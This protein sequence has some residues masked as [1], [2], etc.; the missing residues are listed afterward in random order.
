MK[1]V[2]AVARLFGLALSGSFLTMFAQNKG[3]LC[4]RKVVFFCLDTCRLILYAAISFNAENCPSAQ[5]L[6]QIHAAKILCRSHCVCFAPALSGCGGGRPQL[7]TIIFREVRGDEG[8]GDTYMTST[9][10]G[11]RVPLKQSWVGRLS[12]ISDKFGVK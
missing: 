11:P 2:P 5:I 3:D 10:G 8:G 1:F 12:R 4:T 7:E 9:L 6:S